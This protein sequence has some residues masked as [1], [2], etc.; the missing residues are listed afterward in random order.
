MTPIW[1]LAGQQLGPGLCGESVQWAGDEPLPP[2]GSQGHTALQLDNRTMLGKAACAQSRWAWHRGMGHEDCAGTAST[3]AIAGH[4]C[5]TGLPLWEGTRAPLQDRCRLAAATTWHRKH[6]HA[7]SS[8]AGPAS[9]AC[10]PSCSCKASG[11][12]VRLAFAVGEHG[13]QPAQ[14][15]CA[16]RLVGL[17]ISVQGQLTDSWQSASWLSQ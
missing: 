5:C 6:V 2:S 7:A 10:A 15:A 13:Q 9:K 11:R 17:G 4:N 12:G 3:C 14:H 8:H 1:R 16:P